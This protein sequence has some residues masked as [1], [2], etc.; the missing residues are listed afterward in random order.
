MSLTKPSLISVKTLT[1]SRGQRRG[2]S[3]MRP[4]TTERE[5]PVYRMKPQSE[6]TGD[7]K[8]TAEMTVPVHVNE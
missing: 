2:N 8:S 5:A 4:V 1:F 7:R 6:L 3:G